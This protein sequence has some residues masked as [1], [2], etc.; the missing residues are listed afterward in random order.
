MFTAENLSFRYRGAKTPVF[1]NLNFQIKNGEFV[2]FVGQN[3]SGKSTLARLL[4]GITPLQKGCLKIDDE[5]YLKRQNAKHLRQK[6]GIVFQNP[7]NQIIFS[8]LRDELS[9]TLRNLPQ[10]EVDA[11]IKSVLRRVGMAKY[12]NTNLYEL[13]PGQKQRIV[14]AE[15]LAKSPEYIVLDEPTAMLDPSGKAKIRDILK[16]LRAQGTTV[17]LF[18]NVAEE[19]PLADRAFMLKNGTFLQETSPAKI[20]EFLHASTD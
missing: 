4:A 14:I 2:V 5:I 18:T 16:N 12:E 1:S 11:R 8:N 9:F 10:K 15:I 19:I 3:G 7:D 6:V 13:S 20:M 17:L